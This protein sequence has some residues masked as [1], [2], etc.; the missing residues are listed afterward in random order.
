MSRIIQKNSPLPTDR[1]SG[2]A[3]PAIERL[4]D[5]YNSGRDHMS[6]DRANPE[7]PA[8]AFA[9]KMPSKGETIPDAQGALVQKSGKSH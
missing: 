9:R 8:Q 1:C 5:R 6:L 7:T 4:V 2:P 3:R